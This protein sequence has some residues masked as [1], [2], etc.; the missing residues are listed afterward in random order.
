MSRNHAPQ[1]DK[2][3][4]QRLENHEF[5][6]EEGAEYAANKFGEFGEYL[7]NKKIKLL[8][9]DV[10]IREMAAKDR[11]EQAGVEES[12][13]EEVLSTTSEIFKGCLIH[14]NGYTR[15]SISELHRLIVLNG[16]VFLQYLDGKTAATHIISTGLTPRKMVEFARYRVV[17]PDWIVESIK[18]GILLPWH[19][20]RLIKPQQG[21]QGLQVEV[22]R[23]PVG[24]Q[25][26]PPVAD[27][28]FLENYYKKSRLHHL[29]T[30][31]ADLK[32]KFQNRVSTKPTKSV[33]SSAQRT[34]FHV[35]FDCFFA[36]IAV[37]KQPELADKPVC[38]GNGGSQ[39]AEISSCNYV[40][41]ERGVK[42]GMW[43]HR[44]KELCPDLVCCGY[45]FE[46]YEEASKHLYDVLLSLDADRVEVVSIDEAILDLTSVCQSAQDNDSVKS[47]A[48]TLADKI[49]DDIYRLTSCTVSIGIGCNVLL[50]KLATRKVKPNGKFY[51]DRSDFSAFVEGMSVSN[52]PGIG[53]SIHHQLRE[54]LGVENVLDILKFTKAQLKSALGAK[55]GE[56]LYGYA[57]GEDKYE[58]GQIVQRKSVSA[59]VNWGVRFETR[60][61][62]HTFLD[63]LSGELSRRLHAL[64]SVGKC[65]TLKLYMRSPDA[66][67]ETPKYFG[68]GQ[69][70]AMSRSTV[71]ANSTAQADV[72]AEQAK[73]LLQKLAVQVLDIRGVGLQMTK[74]AQTEENVQQQQKLNAF[75]SKTQVDDIHKPPTKSESP[76]KLESSRA[77]EK[78]NTGWMDY[79]DLDM[80]VLNELPRA[81]RESILQEA[82]ISMAIQKPTKQ[83]IT[84]TTTRERTVTRVKFQGKYREQDVQELLEAWIAD[85]CIDAS[86]PDDEDVALFEK[87]VCDVATV[88]KNVN[89]AVSAVNFLRLQVT[90]AV[91]IPNAEGRTMSGGASAQRYA[92]LAKAW[93]AA[94]ERIRES[95]RKAAKGRI[96]G[97]SLVF[98]F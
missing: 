23:A 47:T 7:H 79:E 20:F 51:L 34:I 18:K 25:T 44:A 50:A 87:Y 8:N 19:E 3:R 77:K 2:A 30:W 38:I 45:D 29:S 98:D 27:P 11:E 73:G 36:S 91:E 49:K 70:D 75:A 10:N 40:A 26:A 86:P 15:P 61:Q 4:I 66:P 63:S 97:G 37:K 13:S 78:A 46:A 76:K 14:I 65:L 55:T 59:E 80:N 95:L 90:I 31:K 81:L 12:L 64:H 71:L 24:P 53:H 42:N 89:K 57:L 60:E 22:Q 9:L 6:S 82:G 92:E 62:V 96:G 32:L 48:L 21:Q 83:Q 68:C 67:V 52:L 41:R 74:L 69:C 54:Q 88:E 43:M 58:V 39:N 16:G 84:F 85:T 93:T 56:K 33:S 72:V 35:D 17:T 5:K 28:D 94:A 1:V